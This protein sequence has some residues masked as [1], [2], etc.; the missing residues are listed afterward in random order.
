M[1]KINLVLLSL[2][3]FFSLPSVAQ[4]SVNP[5]TVGARPKPS[6][7]QTAAYVLSLGAY[8]GYDLNTEAP[9]PVDGLFTYTASLAKAGLPL[10]NVCFAAIPVNS[11]Y[12]SFSDNSAYSVF[13][14][15]ANILFP[16]FNSPS[17][18]GDSDLT[19]VVGFDQEAY[20][21]DFVSQA[22]LDILGTQ[23]NS[24]CADPDDTACLGQSQ[25]MY[26]VLKDIAKDSIPGNAV[27]ASSDYNL[28]F[29]SQLH[30]D[31]LLGPLIYSKAVGTKGD[32]LPNATQEQQA[33][34]YIRYAS[35]LV[36]PVDLMSKTDYDTLSG[37]AKKST[38]GQTDDE[39]NNIHAAQKSLM[40]YLLQLRV[41]ASRIAAPL[42]NLSSIMQKRMPQTVSKTDGSGSSI[43]SEAFNEFVTAT[44]RLYTPGVSDSA[45][46]V[47]Q[48]D[49]AS[50]ATTL[51]EIAIL[52]AEMNQQM[53]LTR[54][55]EERILFTNSMLLLQSTAANPP[56]ANVSTN[57]QTN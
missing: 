37:E 38:V 50:S 27:Y 21:S 41:Y 19:A 24:T 11:A 49:N 18:A 47:K 46:W 29:L 31:T 22:I 2:G 51:K 39:V 23:N 40:K 42:S 30:S 45:Q 1:K 3:L 8:L 25:V 54:Q 43:T 28:R 52:L 4:Y 34:D 33:L 44:W 26:M 35:G 32:G 16:H 53:Y 5:A 57:V 14:K 15:Q 48:I 10:L 17:D 13:N 9:T 20:Q 12:K 55:V 36:L 6:E 7:D 56:N